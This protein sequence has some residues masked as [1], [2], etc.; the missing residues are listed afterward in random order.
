[1]SS[2]SARAVADVVVSVVAERDVGYATFSEVRNVCKVVLYGQTVFYSQND[3]LLSSR[4]VGIK[5]LGRA[6]QSHILVVFGNDVFNLVKDE[7]GI[8]SRPFHIESD[9][10]AE[11]F[12]W[13]RLWQ[14][15]HHG[16]GILA[17]F[18][19][20]MQVY[21]YAWVAL[22]EPNVKREEHRRIAMGVE[23]KHFGVHA[24]GFGEG[25]G[26]LNDPLK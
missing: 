22:V 2:R 13:F 6:G 5:L 16:G 15:S 11:G 19:H 8:V 26:L 18:G 24:L 1:M 9:L 20:L 4:L 21:E 17:P 23:R 7:V 10:L 12:T 14:I 25:F 3:A